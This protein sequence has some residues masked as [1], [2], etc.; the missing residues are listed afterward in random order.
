MIIEFMNK[1]NL[2]AYLELWQTST[3]EVFFEKILNGR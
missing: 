3:T 1:E 2:Q